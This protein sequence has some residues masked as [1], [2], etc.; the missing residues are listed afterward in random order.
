MTRHSALIAA[1]AVGLALDEIT[2]LCGVVLIGPSGSGK[3][4][5]AL[6]M[7]ENCPWRRSRLV[8]DDQVLAEAREGAPWVFTPSKIAG[9]IEVRGFGPA[10]IEYCDKILVQ[11]A[12]DLGAEASRLPEADRFVIAG[13]SVPK[14][15]LP[16]AFQ[17]PGR[18]RVIMRAIIAGQTP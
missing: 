9:L 1:T 16:P 5:L 18:L 12:F 2:P 15:P 10:P 8:G 4:S 14:W 17:S 7:V 11:A 6:E 3:S 13:V